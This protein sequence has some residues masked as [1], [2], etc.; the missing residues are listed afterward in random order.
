LASFEIARHHQQE[1]RPAAEPVVDVAVR[2]QLTAGSYRAPLMSMCHESW[3]KRASTRFVAVPASSS[4]Q[5]QQ[6]RRPPLSQ[7]DV[8]LVMNNVRLA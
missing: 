4:K 1:T 6:P 7:H 2:S 3:W 8:L 5:E